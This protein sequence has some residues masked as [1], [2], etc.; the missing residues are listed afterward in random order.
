M[1]DLNAKP[2]RG[3][4]Q[5]ETESVDSATEPSA[6]DP[7]NVKMVRR[8]TAPLP[9]AMALLSRPRRAARLV[10]SALPEVNGAVMSAPRCWRSVQHDP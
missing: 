3:K 2:G 9:T 8:Q 6:T 1:S 5:L 10:G 7:P 4:A